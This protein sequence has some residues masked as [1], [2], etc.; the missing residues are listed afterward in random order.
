MIKGWVDLARVRQARAGAPGEA[1]GAAAHSEGPVFSLEANGPDSGRAADEFGLVVC[2]GRAQFRSSETQR[3]AQ[4]EGD[5]AV[6]LQLL[7]S[8]GER[9]LDEAGG[10]FAL[11]YLDL[12][13]ATLILATD[14]FAIRP[15]CYSVEGDRLSFASRADA[16]PRRQPAEID[17]QALFE[18]LYFHVIPTPATVYRGVHRLRGAQAVIATAG[19][20]RA[21]LY[22]MPRFAPERPPHLADL[23]REFLDIIR[24]GV[25]REAEGRKTACFLSGGTDSSTVTGML[26]QTLGA[27]PDAYSIG[28]DAQ[29]YD[30]MSYARIAARHFGARHHEYY[31]TPADLVQGIPIVARHYDQPFGNSSALP[32]YYCASQALGDG[33][34]CMLA[35]DGG[36]ELFGGNSRYARQ[37]VFAAYH[38]LPNALRRSV[39]EPMALGMPLWSQVPLLK[40]GV[41]Y[42]RQARLPMPERMETYN[43]LERLGVAQ[44]LT[45]G[46]L[47]TI[48]VGRPR[49]QQREVYAES[50]AD[51]VNAMLAFDWKYTLVDND[52]PKVCG[53]ANL[54]GIGVGFPLL[55]AELTDFSLRLPASLKVRGLTLRYFFKRALR[56]FLPQEILRK[57]KHGFGLPFGPWLL[58][59]PALHALAADSLGG[60]VERGLV[61][62]EF[63]DELLGARVREVPGYYGGMV[64]VLMML[65]QWLRQRAPAYRLG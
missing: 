11:A 48:D 36:D 42:V 30:E 47:E 59:D 61:R 17:P 12:R 27:A 5:A 53:T 22:W 20:V 58:A 57:S 35:G 6:W 54:A 19:A 44:A 9:A 14:R 31:I 7:A 1:T 41:S 46:F 64:W 45:P 21:P 28:F 39:I 34:Q 4:T 25:A 10:A 26:G 37:R 32:A 49:Q 8:R 52:L 50:G 16:V 29:G 15:L 55:T 56:N 63:V 43:L 51:L 38:A 65:E 40:K 18:Y 33:F 2:T 60:V 62:R 13:S 24:A 23:E 3:R